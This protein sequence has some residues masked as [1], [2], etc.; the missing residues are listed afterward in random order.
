MSPANKVRIMSVELLLVVVLL[1]G[2]GRSL[3]LENV[4]PNG[5]TGVI[6][7]RAEAPGGINLQVTNG[8]MVLFFPSSGVLEHKGKLPT[9]EWHRPVARFA[10]G[11]PI[12][13]AG[14]DTSVSDSVVA[15]RGLGIKNKNTESWDFVGTASQ[16]QEAM[17][18]FYGFPMPK[19]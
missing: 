10:D 4:V 9:L 13:I 15:L 6:N 17:N 18:V 12:P 11:T 14:S 7:L 8:K 16:M 1:A 2:C 5:F 19:R 3:E